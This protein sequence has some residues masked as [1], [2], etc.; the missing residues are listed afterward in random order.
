MIGMIAHSIIRHRLMNLRLVV[1]Q[2]SVYLVAATIAGVVFSVIIGLGSQ[3]VGGRPQ[4]VPLPFLVA[5]ALI[6]ALAFEPLKTWLQSTL[7]RYLY[8][9][10]YDYQRTLREASSTISGTLDLTSLLE[11]LCGTANRVLRPDLVAAFTRDSRDDTFWRVARIT[12][13]EIHPQLDISRVSAA[14]PLPSFLVSARRPLVRDE[15]G[16]TLHGSSADA[17]MADLRALGGDVAI[18][19]LSESQLVGFLIVGTKLSGDAYFTDDIELLSTLSNQAAIAVNNAQLYGRVLLVNE[20]IENILR[21]MDSGVVTVDAAGHV[22][23]VNA[24]AESLTRLPLVALR[25]LSVDTLPAPLASQLRDTLADGQPR[26]QVEASLPVDPGHFLPIVCS[27]AALRDQRGAIH[28]ALVVFSDLSKLKALETEKRRAERL[29]AFG[30]LV[31]G[32]AHEIKNPL[33]A[34]KT[35]AELLPERFQ[36]TDFREDFAKVVITEIDRIDDLVARLRGLAI[37]TPHQTGAIDIREPITDTLAL[38]R[39]QLEQSRVTVV[40]EFAD[41]EP[42]VVA[43]IPQ[44]KQLFLNLFINALEAMGRDGELTVRISR[45]RIQSETWVVAEVAD[46]GPGIPESIQ[47]NIFNPFFTTKPRGSGLGLA[48][49]RGIVD[50]HRGTIRA[51]ARH[52]RRGTA[53]IVEFPASFRNPAFAESDVL[54]H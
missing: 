41:D 23:V 49:C 18:P 11:Y 53:L 38:L 27:T 1:R 52:D 8:R 35:F 42:Y 25:S 26:L 34:I 13:S 21:T 50:A 4:D 47:A 37:P 54:R 19:M 16:R 40:R 31:S 15:I 43:D 48:I 24:T 10:T 44:L 32:I 6:L 45:K 5:I 9:E 3:L 30:T 17:A 12:V 20:Y 28:G 29:A 22:A 7:D 39:A 33:V 36:E 2:G 14:A 51:E 46:T